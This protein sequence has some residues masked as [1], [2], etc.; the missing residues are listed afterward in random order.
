MATDRHSRLYG[1]LDHQRRVLPYSADMRDV[2]TTEF[3]GARYWSDDTSSLVVPAVPDGVRAE[4]EAGSGS[5]GWVFYESGPGSIGATGPSNSAPPPL[6]ADILGA[7]FLSAAGVVPKVP[8]P[9]SPSGFSYK[10]SLRSDESLAQP[11]YMV[12]TGSIFLPPGS[13]RA[14]VY[15]EA[16]LVV[17]V[18]DLNPEVTP[19]TL[20]QTF[21]ANFASVGRPRITGYA[22]Y[23]V[24]AEQV[25]GDNL[26][27]PATGWAAPRPPPRTETPIIY[28]V[29]KASGPWKY[30]SNLVL[31]FD[32]ATTEREVAIVRGVAGE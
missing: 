24:P 21:P 6:G 17:T 20:S 26:F 30:A 2:P 32:P 22:L 10:L 27:D 5:R 25:S 29:T 12:R 13:D 18:D 8:D 16:V 19:G 28:A 23:S 3:L 4:L 9:E 11:S 14:W 15:E 31:A 7:Q 1:F